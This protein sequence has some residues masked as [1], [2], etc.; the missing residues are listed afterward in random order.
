MLRI[1]FNPFSITVCSPKRRC[2]LCCP[3]L[4]DDCDYS[5][6]ILQVFGFRFS[7]AVFPPANPTHEKPLSGVNQQTTALPP[8]IKTVIHKKRWSHKKT[9]GGGTPFWNRHC[10]CNENIKH[11]DWVWKTT[12][13]RTELTLQ[14][15]CFRSCQYTVWSWSPRTFSFTPPRPFRSCSDTEENKQTLCKLLNVKDQFYFK[16]KLHMIISNVPLIISSLDFLRYSCGHC[17]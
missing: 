7:P 5:L 1:V 8:R 2:S 14:N 11:E 4:F 17:W 16:R 9:G 15:F 10:Q 6:R 13:S 3:S 12:T